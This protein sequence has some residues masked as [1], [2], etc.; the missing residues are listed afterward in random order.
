MTDLTRRFMLKATGAIGASLVSARRLAAAAPQPS[1][2]SSSS[3]IRDGS[4]AQATTYLFLNSDEASFVEAAV[5]R[6]IPEDEQWPWASQRR[7]STQVTPIAR[8]VDQCA[9]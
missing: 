1:D 7:G 3:A 5:A 8:T 4:N 9:V 6:L 2:A